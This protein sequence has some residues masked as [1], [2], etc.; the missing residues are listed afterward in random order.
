MPRKTKT[1]TDQ[2]YDSLT[3]LVEQKD[4]PPGKDISECGFK[5]KW[6]FT[7]YRTAYGGD[8][9]R[10][11]QAI[12]NDLQAQVPAAINERT[13]GRPDAQAQEVLSL[14][15]L[16]PQPDDQQLAGLSMQQM[17]ER[18]LH[19]SGDEQA[20]RPMNTFRPPMLGNHLFLLVDEE[21][22]SAAASGQAQ[23]LWVKCVDADYR[24]EDAVP[25]NTRVRQTYFG[26]MKMTT[27]SLVDFRQHL[28]MY[29]E[30]R[31][32]APHMLDEVGRDAMVWDG[33]AR[34]FMDSLVKY[35]LPGS[36]TD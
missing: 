9:E 21:V 4:V 8:S 18:F 2:I 24:A 33:I 7:V 27:R 31:R 25:R 11:W 20:P 19:A 12:I 3:Q 13:E 10:Y 22:I 6:G 5:E 34:G 26:W 28:Q 15:Q 1:M 16:D 30:F 14:F 23:Q 36:T 17:R 35:G 29:R 32:I